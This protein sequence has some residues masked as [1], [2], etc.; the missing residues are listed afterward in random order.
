MG[1]Q[2]IFPRIRDLE[3]EPSSEDVKLARVSKYHRTMFVHIAR[4]THLWVLTILVRSLLLIV[5]NRNATGP[6]KQPGYRPGTPHG[7]YCDT[8]HSLG[9]RVLWSFLNIFGRTRRH[10]SPH[11]SNVKCVITANIRPWQQSWYKP[12]TAGKGAWQ[13]AETAHAL[14]IQRHFFLSNKHILHPVQAVES[15][16]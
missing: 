5:L 13:V 1:K 2:A 4:T 12:A 6:P 3:K 14:S 9:H 11:T 8:P 10:A 16:W 15:A 7:L